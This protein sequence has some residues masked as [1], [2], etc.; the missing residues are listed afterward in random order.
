[1][2][3]EREKEDKDDFKVFGLRNL[4]NGIVIYWDEE[5][6]EKAMAPHSST[7]NPRDGGAWWAAIY[8]VAQSQTLLKWLNSRDEED[9]KRSRFEGKKINL[10]LKCLLNIPWRS[11]IDIW[12]HKWIWIWSSGKRSRV[13]NKI[14]IRAHIWILKTMRLGEITKGLV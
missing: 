14:V 8:G 13:R 7:L 11:W 10:G 1:M 4:K 6:S 5:D 2:G 9:Y 3:C 12:T